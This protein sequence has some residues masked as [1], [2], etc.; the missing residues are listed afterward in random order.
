MI[1]WLGERHSWQAINSKIEMMFNVVSWRLHIDNMM[2]LTR[3]RA[4]ANVR[5]D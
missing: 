1:K 2:G 5:A 4:L 3:R